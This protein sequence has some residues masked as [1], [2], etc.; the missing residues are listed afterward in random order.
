MNVYV[1]G[2]I[3]IREAGLPHLVTLKNVITDPV[4][5]SG[6]TFQ[7]VQNRVGLLYLMDLTVFGNP[8]QCMN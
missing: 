8:F 5:R 2:I 7:K 4:R 6:R 3:S 1:G